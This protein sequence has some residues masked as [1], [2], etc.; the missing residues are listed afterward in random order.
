M[1]KPG[2]QEMFPRLLLLFEVLLIGT[3]LLSA[4]AESRDRAMNP[5]P[6]KPVSSSH[7]PRLLVLTDIGGDPD[8]QQSMIRLMTHANEFE[9]EGLIASAS[10]TPGELKR[11]LVRPD[12]IREIVESY[13][14]VRGNLSLHAP[15]YP[16]EGELRKRIKAGNPERGV[17]N[18]G[19]GKDTKG[20]DWIIAAVDRPDP[21]PINVTIWGGSTELA[22]ALWRVRNDRSPEEV[23]RFIGKLRVHAIGHQDDTGPWIVRE[24]PDLFY[25]LSAAPE[26][27][28]KRESAY[29]GMYLGGDE[30]LTSRE[31][32]ETHVKDGHGP[33]GALYP[34]KT[35]TAP[36]PHSTLKEGDTPS[37]FYFLPT[38]LSDPAHPEWGSWGGRFERA[39]GGLY[40][41]VK[42][43]MGGTTD[44]RATVWRWR[45][46]FQNE[47]RARMD[48]NVKPYRE[49]NH[50]PKVILN[51]DGTLAV[52]RVKT[53][54]GKEV[55]LSAK[56]SADPDGGKL[57]YRWG[58]YPEAG[59]YRGK[60]DLRD[61]REPE[62]VLLM[63]EGAGGKSIHVILEVTDDGIPPLTRYRRILVEGK[64]EGQGE[65]KG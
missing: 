20:S 39:A 56:G 33:L 1:R 46:A 8:D 9:I 6:M 30:S 18:L 5:S 62:A 42:D 29:R 51:G 59:T 34:M 21:R 31:W 2:I 7:K 41:D 15:G 63:P 44:A 19:E 55:R 58:T 54:P 27:R 65:G 35:W 12:L 16:S 53:A 4:T 32:I 14:K 64:G 37:W 50:P 45:P 47:F 25:I 28:D 26:G 11:D 57:S 24:F 40:R 17:A 3:S 49:A 43:T 38:G 36:N 13:G 61:A 23:K 10:G 48:W 52:L 22:Q 60:V